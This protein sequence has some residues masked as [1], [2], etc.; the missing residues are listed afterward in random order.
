MNDRTLVIVPTAGDAPPPRQGTTIVVM[1]ITW[2]PTLGDRPDLI[3]ARQLLGRVVERVDLFDTALTLIDRWAATTSIADTLTVEGT[4]YWYRL[5]ESM[6]RWLHERLLWRLVIADLERQGPIEHVELLVDEPALADVARVRWPAPLIV[7]ERLASASESPGATPTPSRSLVARIARR[8][9]GTTGTG[10]TRTVA[11]SPASSERDRRE[12]VLAAR[13]EALAGSSRSRVTVLTNPGTHQR[14]GAPGGER[15]DPLFG[16]VIPGLAERG[17]QPVLLATGLD[18]R[19]DDD[20]ALIDDDDRLLPQYL[21]ATRWSRPEDDERATAAVDS[22]LAAIDAAATTPLDLDGVDMSRPFLDAVRAAATQIIRTDVRML[23]RI[24]RL[25]RE[26]EP[27][28]IVLAQEGIRTPWLMAG[29]GAGVPVMA[30]QHGVLY[31]GHA[32]FAN[33]R[34]PALCLPDRTCVYGTFERDVLLDL[35]Y[36]PD[37]VVVT[38]SPRLDLDS[39]PADPDLGGAERAAVRRELGVA[40][41]HR[42]LVVSTVN[43]RFVQRSH[44]AHM[45]EAVLGAPLP[46]VH[47]VFKQHPGERDEGPYR[48]L[49]LGLA[50]ARG[51]APP[52]ISVVKDIDLYRLL[53]AADAHLGLLSTV[54]TEAVVAGTPNLIALT[55]GHT[56]LLGYV[57]AGVARPVRTPAE[58]LAALDA[59]EAPD[60]AARQAFLDRHFRS[61][62]ASGRIIDEVEAAIGVTSPQVVA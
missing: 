21:L 3:A 24:E 49:L 42:L 37:D 59:P 60:P 35:A 27:A 10:Q 39:V 14:I 50:R 11:V 38:G 62:D 28:A 12:A 54:L 5:R 20:W 40:D 33:R 55:D 48:D 61:G 57:A 58:L 46:D 41:G 29:R 26:L 15:K 56:D 44:F 22:V 16:A 8:L 18:Q 6:W 2:T 9:R 7:P 47:V 17:Y 31:A 52:A 32:G 13:A 1:D 23:A 4:T 25:L 51:Y 36:T 30:V 53:R 19:R 45:L 34:H 43:L